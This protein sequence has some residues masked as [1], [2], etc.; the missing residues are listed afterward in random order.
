M[1]VQ[2]RNGSD[3]LEDRHAGAHAGRGHGLTR[4][5]RAARDTAW[6]DSCISPEAGAASVT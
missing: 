5:G 6:P 3:L 4:G 2:Y 1:F